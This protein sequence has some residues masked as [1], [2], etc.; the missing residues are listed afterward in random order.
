MEIR[1]NIFGSKPEAEAFWKIIDKWGPDYFI[2]P[3]LPLSNILSISGEELSD[4]DR[5]YFYSASVD[6]TLCTQEGSP[7]LSIEFDGMGRG[8]SRNGEYVASE[9]DVPRTRKRTM[10]FKLDLAEISGY[11]LVVISGEELKILRGNDSLTIL[12]GIIGQHIATDKNKKVLGEAH[13]KIVEKAKNLPR[14]KADDYIQNYITNIWSD[15]E[16]E[17]DPIV[18]ASVE[19]ANECY[20]YGYHLVQCEYLDGP[21]V[22]SFQCPLEIDQLEERV[23]AIMNASKLGCRVTIGKKGENLAVGEVFV[24]NIN[25]IGVVSGSLAKNVAEF[26]AYKKAARVLQKR[27]RNM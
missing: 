18:R 20:E 7:L 13:N 2:F 19:Y 14:E 12:D 4:E 1:K 3:S 17:N 16:I 22:P 15:C 11:P 5:K 21:D 24:R 9:I 27:Q 25:T 26:I 6:Y 23:E 10:K 8:F